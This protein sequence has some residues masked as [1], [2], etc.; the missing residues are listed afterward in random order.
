[1]V[2]K[3]RFLGLH[4][5]RAILEWKKGR[6]QIK[7]QSLGSRSSGSSFRVLR[8]WWNWW[9]YMHMYIWYVCMYACICSCVYACVQRPGIHTAWAC[10]PQSFFTLFFETGPLIGLELTYYLDWQASKFWD[11]FKLA[12]PELGLQVHATSFSFMQRCWAPNQAFM[13]NAS[14]TVPSPQPQW[15][16]I[17]S[18]PWLSVHWERKWAPCTC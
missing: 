9:I 5:W 13:L 14:S 8:W 3:S 16:N 6:L 11:L 17:L 15:T 12:F 7:D 2:S 18:L 4:F 1:M 10:H